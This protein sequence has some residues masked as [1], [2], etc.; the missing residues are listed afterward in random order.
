VWSEKAFYEPVL[1]DA[2]KA[3]LKNSASDKAKPRVTG[4]RKATGLKE[5]AG[6]AMK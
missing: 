6:L 5:T 2:N 4:G 3:S 1:F